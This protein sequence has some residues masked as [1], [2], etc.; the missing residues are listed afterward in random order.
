MKNYFNEQFIYKIFIIDPSST[1]AIKCIIIVNADFKIKYWQKLSSL[2]YNMKRV[3]KQKKQFSSISLYKPKDQ[4]EVHMER[5]VNFEY[6]EGLFYESEFGG[7][8]AITKHNIK[9]KKQLGASF[10]IKY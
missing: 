3:S 2:Q 4:I 6:F 7:I 9:F 5:L 8:L 1:N 10:T